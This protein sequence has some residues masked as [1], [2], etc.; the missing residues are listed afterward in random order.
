[1]FSSQNLSSTNTYSQPNLAESVSLIQHL[2]NQ[3]KEAIFCLDYQGHFYYINDAACSLLGHSRQKLLNMTIDE[4]EMDFLPS[5]WSYYWQLLKQQTSL[6]FKK[7]CSSQQYQSIEVTIKFLEHGSELLG[8]ILAHTFSTNNP[9]IAC[10][11]DLYLEQENQPVNSS[12]KSL[13]SADFYPN[14]VQLR[15]IFEFIEQNYHLPISLN[16]VAQA[17][18]YSPAYL[19]NLVKRRTQLTIIDWI[20]ERKMLEARSL[21][22]N[23][24]KSV[25][26][27]AM[28][29]GFTDAYYF[30]RRFSQYHKL[31]PR[32][33]RQKYHYLQTIN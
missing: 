16:D 21:L 2:I 10:D 30:S 6:T 7:V 1:M 15:P 22:I 13:S 9:D 11:Q 32:S 19:T 8:C 5:S 12:N 25:T 27:I 26:E 33:W 31:S 3:V 29:V 28:A 20:L 24:D 18:G 23:S 17:V 4:V 14:C